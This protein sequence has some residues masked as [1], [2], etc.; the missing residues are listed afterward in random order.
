MLEP[1][2]PTKQEQEPSLDSVSRVEKRRKTTDTVSDSEASAE[3]K[4][5]LEYEED[6]KTF[7]ADLQ[8]VS[9]YYLRSSLVGMTVASA[10]HKGSC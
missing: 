1:F 5:K 10:R 7:I 4:A 2:F 3:T 9:C 6:V 8:N